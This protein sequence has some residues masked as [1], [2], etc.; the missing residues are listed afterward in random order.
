MRGELPPGTK[1]P[2]TAELATQTGT[3]VNV[4]HLAL[5]E[6]VREGLVTRARKVGT[7]VADRKPRL[8]SLGIYHGIDIEAVPHAGFLQRLNQEL[9]AQAQA[10]QIAVR[11]WTDSRA[12]LEQ[13][14]S[15]PSLDKAVLDRE[16]G[17]LITTIA[18]TNHSSWLQNLPLPISYLGGEFPSSVSSDN[19]QF[20]GASIEV[21]KRQGCR[22]I[23]LV[24]THTPASAPFYRDFT[25]KCE[26]LGIVT[27]EE[28]IIRPQ[29]TLPGTHHEQFGYQAF[30][31]LW[32]QENRPEGLIVFPDGAVRG[33]LLALMSRQ[34]RVPQDIKLVLHQN[35]G[36]PLLCPVPATF[37]VFQ[38][39]EVASALLR[40]VETVF[41]G[42]LPHCIKI[43][44]K[45]VAPAG[46]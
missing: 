42:G 29:E 36:V 30:H 13:R 3:N 18:D 43:K 31:R 7:Y 28:W 2:S 5:S 17:G 15:L 46:L 12:T 19:G 24:A 20:I 23:G 21:L 35:E 27:G 45:I 4:I 11:I 25:A 22:S 6:L 39:S 16:I 44:H 10:R 14:A 32:D 37:A 1:L 9:Q 40:Q 41:E 33:L 26:A 34:V 38:I 8:A